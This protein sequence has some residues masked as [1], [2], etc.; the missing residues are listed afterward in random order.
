MNIYSITIIF[1]SKFIFLYLICELSL[2]IRFCGLVYNIQSE[3]H[4]QRNDYLAASCARGPPARP[5]TWRTRSGGW[6]VGWT[7]RSL[8]LFCFFCFFRSPLFF[9]FLFQ[10]FPFLFSFFPFLFSFFSFFL[11]ICIQTFNTYIQTLY[12]YIKNVY[13]KNQQ[14]TYMRLF[15]SFFFPG[16]FF[17]F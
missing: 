16:R 4:V 1:I 11:Y 12:T 7:A 6:G 8:V 15:L 2:Y 17:G 13:I 5:D 9:P 3:V 14:T 10:F